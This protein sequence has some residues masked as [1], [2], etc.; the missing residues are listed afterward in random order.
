MT[1]YPKIQTVFKRNPDTGFKTLIEGDYSLP[2]FEYLKGNDW[3]WSEKVNGT[4]IRIL[5]DGTKVNFGGK[6]NNSQIPTPLTTYLMNKFFPA[7]MQRVFADTPVCLY[8]EGYGAKIQ[9]GGN[10]RPD[11]SFVLF[12]VLINGWWLERTNIEGIAQG[13]DIDIV[14]IIGVGTLTEMVEMTRAGFKSQW[15]DF[16]AE[17]IVAR[18][19][20][21]LFSRNNERIITKI[22]HKDFKVQK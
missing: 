22:K 8:G 14:P 6:T 1:E 3:I 21:E 10:Y 15:G 19:K 9:S 13:L 4:N 11:Q 5:W 7:D 18:P 16:T 20:V 12:D 17:G 2:E